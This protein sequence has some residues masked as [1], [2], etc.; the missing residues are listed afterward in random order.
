MKVKQR[1]YKDCH[2]YVYRNAG[3]QFASQIGYICYKKRLKFECPHQCSD[4]HD[5]AVY[6]HSKE[7]LLQENFPVVVFFFF[8]LF[9]GSISRKLFL[10]TFRE[11]FV[12][13]SHENRCCFDAEWCCK[14]C[15]YRNRDYNRVFVDNP[16]IN[17]E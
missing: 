17:S 7:I 10:G 12:K 6:R 14:C 16:K 4:K 2:H 11:H 1:A 8:C 5:S 9:F 3:S 15:D 13:P